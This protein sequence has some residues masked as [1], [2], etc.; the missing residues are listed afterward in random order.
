MK[1]TNSHFGYKV[2]RERPISS[3]ESE[4]AF[5]ARYDSADYARPA[6]AVDLV[7]LGLSGARPAILLLQRDRHPHAGRHALP[8]GFVG[9]DEALED[10]AA[11]VLR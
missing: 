3:A 1:I 8:G 6:V 10:A 11:R 4:A 9:I 5:L 2:S 7:L